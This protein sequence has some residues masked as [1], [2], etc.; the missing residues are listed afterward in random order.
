MIAAK[1]QR[2]PA[3]GRSAE[4]SR[5][6]RGCHFLVGASLGYQSVNWM[7]EVLPDY[8]HNAGRCHL[9]CR[10]VDFSRLTI[11]WTV[12]NSAIVQYLFG[13]LLLYKIN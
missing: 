10:R 1:K 8:N 5:H 7:T 11:Y 13:K 9:H 3:G 6:R 2:L 4:I 12:E